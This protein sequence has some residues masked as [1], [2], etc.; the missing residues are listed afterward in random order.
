MRNLGLFCVGIASLGACKWS[1]FDDLKDEAWVSATTKPDNGSTNW[2]VAIARG[3]RAGDPAKLAVIGTAESL[4]NEIEF[5]A[6][7]GAKI[8]GNEQKLN[9][10]FGIGN[11]EAQPILL[12]DPTSDDIALVT[13]SGASQVVVLRGTSGDLNPHQIFGPDTADAATYMVAPS[14]DG[15][16]APGPQPGLL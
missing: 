13:K 1:E 6:D 9:A 12:A 11:L 3:A 2:G 16:P 10:Q 5:R 7:G 8:A 15:S 4:Y 14:V